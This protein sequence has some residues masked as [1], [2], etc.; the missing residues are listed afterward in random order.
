M[1]LDIAMLSSAELSDSINVHNPCGNE[2]SLIESRPAIDA[3][4]VLFR[5]VLRDAQ[6]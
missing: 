3:A 1:L 5:A 2:L 4:A 6:I